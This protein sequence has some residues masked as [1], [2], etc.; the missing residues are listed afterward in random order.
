M[1]TLAL[2][3]G[4]GGSKG[5][6]GKNHRLVAGRPCIAWTI[7][8]A[9]AARRAGAVD[10]VALST[11][12]R[13]LKAIARQLEI[14]VI[15]RPPELAS[16][17][18]TVDDT[19]RHAVRGLE[20]HGSPSIDAV[21]IL[22]AN[23]P[24]RPPRLIERAA[25][26]LLAS[27]ADSV[28]SYAPVGKHHPWWTAVVGEQGEVRPWEGDLLN[29]GVFRRQD[30]PAAHVPDGGVLAV[31]RA[32]LFLDIPGVAPGP[33]RFFGRDRRGIVTEVGSVVDIDT[34]IDLIVA[35]AILHRRSESVALTS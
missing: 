5:L 22:Y 4:R 17:H 24:V 21:V 14:E 30:L 34:E 33:H 3:L 18:A 23:V 12:S 20:Q 11:D 10:R 35:D 2:I 16:D 8:A 32:A 15:E 26:L 25:G 28:Q 6:P 27:G 29:H 31:T 19:A 1:T 13:E 9:E 7:D